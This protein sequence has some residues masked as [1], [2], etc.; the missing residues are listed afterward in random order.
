MNDNYLWDRTGEP[1]AEIQRLEEVLGTLRYEPR[2]LAIPAPSS[3]SHRRL[4]PTLAIAATIALMVVAA[5]L[6][7]A[8]NRNKTPRSLAIETVPAE[9][10][11]NDKQAP[12]TTPNSVVPKKP[13]PV[14]SPAQASASGPHLRRNT[15]M[16]AR[17]VPRKHTNA[18]PPEL[19]AAE[20]AEAQEAKEQLMLALHVASTKLNFAQRKTRG[21]PATNT[22][23]NQ[24]K[25]G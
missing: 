24:H 11:S 25:I 8:L 10:K 9:Q 23:R 7:F 4:F 17:N 15:N 5:G 13:A 21:V 20:L 1:D 3:F 14:E 12:V 2:P 18:S 16:Q 19:T 6:W 22:I